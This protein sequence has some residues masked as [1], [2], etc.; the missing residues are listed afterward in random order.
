[1]S[2]LARSEAALDP[3]PARPS[4]DKAESRLALWRRQYPPL[5]ALISSGA[6]PGLALRRLG[7]TLWT[8]GRTQDAAEALAEAVVFAPQDSAAWLDLGFARRACGDMRE[9]LEAFEETARLAPADARAWLAIGLVTKALGFV[10][11]AEAAF[12]A[13]LACDPG[14]DDATYS[15]GLVAFEARRYAE[16]ASRWRGLVA[17]GYAAP[18]LL[19]GLGQCQFFLGEFD[20][21]AQSLAAH[22]QTS[23][24]D[25]EARKRHQLV[26]FL[27]GAVRGGPEGARAAFAGSGGPAAREAEVAR[28]SAPLLAAYGYGEAALAVARDVHAG[29]ESDPVHNY[30]LATLAGEKADRAPVGYVAAYFDRFAETFDTQMVE[31]L[32]YRG[33]AKLLRLLD[34]TGAAFGRVLDLGCGT[35]LAGPLLRPRAQNLVG[36]DLS[37]KMIAKARARGVYD[38]LA[39]AEMVEFLGRPQAPFDIVF[40][41]DSLIYLG[42]LGPL[43]EAAARALRPGG[44]LAATVE[45]TSRAPYEQTSSGRFAHAPKALIASGAARGFSLRAIRRGFL[46]LEAHRRVYGALVVLEREAA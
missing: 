26:S 35:G 25:E 27:D 24:A 44:L 16:G 12:E 11:R 46:R 29:A 13:A 20:A 38:D 31:V 33:P 14:L 10:E 41:A 37:P 4:Q 39:E 22:L 21:A 23:P 30:H 2:A 7:L 28:M 9:A 36:V 32:Q 17:R 6:P 42:D 19:L 40:A 1:M 18:A 5:D 8:A 15:L 43:L 3:R 34:E 45:P